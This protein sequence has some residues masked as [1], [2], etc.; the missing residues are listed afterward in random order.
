LWGFMIVV[1]MFLTL[2]V[3]AIFIPFW[4]TQ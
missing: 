2:I 4:A 3:M 1:W